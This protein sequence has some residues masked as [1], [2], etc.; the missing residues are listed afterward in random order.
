MPFAFIIVLGLLLNLVYVTSENDLTKQES[1]KSAEVDSAVN[2]IV[3]YGTYI[4]ETASYRA[5]DGTFT[6]RALIEGYTGPA[7]TIITNIK[8]AGN[9]P[10]HLSWSQPYPAHDA[11]LLNRNNVNQGNN[12]SQQ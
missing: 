5:S 7:S 10:I 3:Y 8:T 2:A 6:N 4:K 1:I 11:M 12:E 9:V